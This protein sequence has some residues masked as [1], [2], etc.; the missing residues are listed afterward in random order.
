[1]IPL[2]YPQDI[3]KLNRLKSDYVLAYSD[4]ANME[5]EWTRLRAAYQCLN[6]FPQSMAEIMKADYRTLIDYYI[7]YHRI[8]KFDRDNMKS[9]LVTLFNYDD[10]YRETIKVFLMN[11]A[12]GFEINTCHYCNMAYVNRHYTD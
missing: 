1:M 5:T 3:V 9:S 4:L 7:S 10:E 6:V 11:S 12:N 8:S 2:K